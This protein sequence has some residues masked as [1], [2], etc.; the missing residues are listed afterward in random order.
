MF[1]KFICIPKI[2]R[3][4][5]NWGGTVGLSTAHDQTV[6]GFAP[7]FNVKFTWLR[8]VSALRAV[9]IFQIRNQLGQNVC[10][11]R[12]FWIPR[13][14]FQI[15]ISY[16][17]KHPRNFVDDRKR[18]SRTGGTVAKSK[19]LHIQRVFSQKPPVNL[20]VFRFR[21]INRHFRP[22]FFP[23]FRDMPFEFQEETYRRI[24][25]LLCCCS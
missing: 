4:A 14:H 2:P 19:K 15:F 25:L 22:P 11:D 12:V 7:Q 8:V 9:V 1:R 10:L 17:L 23:N 13:K 20:A 6:V 5:L 24:W 21:P 16:E 18:F 3:T